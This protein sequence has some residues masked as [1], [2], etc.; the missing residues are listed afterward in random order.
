MTLKD[1]A[2]IPLLIICIA[3]YV[4][5]F[6]RFYELSASALREVAILKHRM[7]LVEQK[8]GI[9]WEQEWK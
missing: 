4:F 2:P 1:L 9:K 5:T 6:M 8:F 3:L 7:N